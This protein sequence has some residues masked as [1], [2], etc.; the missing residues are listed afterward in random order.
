MAFRINLYIIYIFFLFLISNILSVKRNEIN[1]FNDIFLL[2]EDISCEDGQVKVI[3]ENNSI[4]CIQNYCSE[5]DHKFYINGDCIEKC[6]QALSSN[7]TDNN[8]ICKNCFNNGTFFYV[9]YYINKCVDV[10]PQNSKNAANEKICFQCPPNDPF[11]F[12]GGCVNEADCIGNNSI[13]HRGEYCTYCPD[14]Q[15][16]FNN[17]CIDKC[18][19]PYINK[20][21]SPTHICTLCDEGQYYVSGNCQKDC[22]LNA[23]Y[24]EED[25]ACHLCFCNDNGLCKEKTSFKCECNQNYFGDSCE[26]LRKDSEN[27]LKI[28]PLNN[29]ILISDATYFTF[30]KANNA[31]KK[32]K[33]EFFLNN[34]EITSNPKYKKYFITGTNE[35]IFGINPNLYSERYKKIILRLTVTDSDDKVNESEIR[36]YG[37]KLDI[38]T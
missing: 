26:Y 11:Y 34:E 2:E 38:E 23:Y 7:E 15:F 25:K 19:E 32:I 24:L 30:N 22:G 1:E 9:N 18:E 3:Y 29:K 35:K 33:W 13:T 27:Q 16:Y 20:D 37:Q 14:D 17:E 5:Q 4:S 36:I 12:Y 10:C 21:E 8:T 28:E 6:I 31:Y